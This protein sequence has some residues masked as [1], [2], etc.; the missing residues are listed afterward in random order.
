[1]TD[2][3]DEFRRR[4]RLSRLLLNWQLRKISYYL[5]SSGV[6]KALH[7]VWLRVMR[8]IMSHESIMKL[9]SADN[10]FVIVASYKR[11]ITQRGRR[12]IRI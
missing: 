1:M 2:A 3:G 6:G 7:T 4:N 5:V 10:G 12:S 8:L 9:A 11:R